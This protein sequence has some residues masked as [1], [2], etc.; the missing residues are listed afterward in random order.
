MISQPQPG[1]GWQS[2]G[3]SGSGVTDQAVVGSGGSQVVRKSGSVKGSPSLGEVSVIK[4]SQSPTGSRRP[5]GGAVSWGGTRRPN[6][7]RV[8]KSLAY[9]GQGWPGDHSLAVKVRP[10]ITVG[11]GRKGCPGS[12]SATVRP[13]QREHCRSG[14]TVG[15][16][17]RAP[18]GIT[19]RGPV[20]RH[21]APPSSPPVHLTAPAASYPLLP[22]AGL[23]AQ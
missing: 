4:W 9:E 17:T 18:M 3:G 10:R 2:L 22:A 15:Q 7:C 8:G 16:G 23:G 11:Q 19:A 1:M 12:W 13:T 5:S 6:Q 20:P 21:A 14:T